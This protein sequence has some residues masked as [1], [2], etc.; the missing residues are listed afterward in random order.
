MLQTIEAVYGHGLRPL[1]PLTL[2]ENHKVQIII[3]SPVSKTERKKLADTLANATQKTL[4]EMVIED[5][6]N[7]RNLFFRYQRTG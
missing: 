4:S 2:T 3:S 1:S 5:G 7:E 6:D